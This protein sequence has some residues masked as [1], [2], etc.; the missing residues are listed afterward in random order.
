MIEWADVI[1]AAPIIDLENELM[2]ESLLPH[3]I[4]YALKG[5]FIK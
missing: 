1:N 3:S 5:V 4:Y 2:G